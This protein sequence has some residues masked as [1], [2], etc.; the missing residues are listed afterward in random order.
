MTH[1]GGGLTSQQLIKLLLVTSELL[2]K[3]FIALCNS[4]QQ[5]TLIGLINVAN[6]ETSHMLPSHSNVMKEAMKF[7]TCHLHIRCDEK[8]S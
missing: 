5:H 1:K 3:M 8:V 6:H 2:S 4:E 7:H